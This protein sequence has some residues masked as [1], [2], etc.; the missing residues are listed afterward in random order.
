[1]SSGTDC[2]HLCFIIPPYI[3][4]AISQSEENSAETRRNAAEALAHSR[5]IHQA[6]ST[7]TTSRPSAD[8]HPAPHTVAPRGIV[9]DNILRNLAESEHTDAETKKSAQRTLQHSQEL[10]GIR[11]QEKDL[12]TGTATVKREI[13]DA[14]HNFDNSLLPGTLVRAE[15]QAQVSVA[16]AA[17][18]ECYD[19]FGYTYDFYSQVL[20]RNS[21]DN[22]GLTLIGSVHFGQQYGNAFWNSTQMVF[23]DG[24][25]FIYNFTNS[26]DVIG[27]EL[28]HGVTQATAQLADHNQSGALNESVSD[29]FGIQVKQYH[30][31]QKAEEADWLIGEDCLLPGV[32]GVAL[33][34]M[35]A[36]GTA[37]NDP[38]FG[39]D[40][41]P[42][43]LADYVQSSD[44]SDGDFGGVH[45]NSGIP[46]KAFY[47]TAIGCGG[48]SWEKAGKIWYNTLLDP[49][50]NPELDFKG[51]ADITV[52]VASK[53]FDSATADIVKKAWTDVGVYDQAAPQ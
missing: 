24:N 53:M 27:H 19:N 29:V 7:L 15:G 20:G 32:Q 8:D 13:H 44:N 39:Q 10:R 3:L 45:T 23:G 30:L 43:T 26:L 41:Q 22:R 31:K 5:L 16:D 28:T 33:R 12:G 11:A 17:V 37:Y 35:K 25:D 52:S 51:F 14:N 40:P 42:A 1:M 38:R 36:P 34:S 46:N 21:I 6:R 49:N 2:G 48:Y 4:H 50:M 9:P 47:L 18:S